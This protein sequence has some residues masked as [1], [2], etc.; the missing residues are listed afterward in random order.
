VHWHNWS[1]KERRGSFRWF[2]T[3]TIINSSIFDQIVLY[4][5]IQF[6]SHMSCLIFADPSN[7]F[8]SDFQIFWDFSKIE[9]SHVPNELNKMVTYQN[10][11]RMINFIIL[12]LFVHILRVW[13]FFRR[14]HTVHPLIA[15]IPRVWT[16]SRGCHISIDCFNCK[17]DQF[18][19]LIARS[20]NIFQDMSHI[21]WL[22]QLQAW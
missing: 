1:N 5:F 18:Y 13:T 21:H 10:I 15:S 19:C 9:K 20:S 22:L 4:Y 6:V 11:I 16:F 8:F 12:I 3:A 14:C 17:P 7:N 2:P